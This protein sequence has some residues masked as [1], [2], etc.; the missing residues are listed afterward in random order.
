MSRYD[1]RTTLFN[2]KGRL[3]QVEY[4]L[5]AI[6]HASTALGI[7]AEDGVLLAT[8]KKIPSK[9]LEVRRSEKI[10]QIDKHIGCAVAG[11]T[12]DSNHIID[13]IRVSAQRHRVRFSEPTSVEAL[14]TT[15]ADHMQAYTQFGG[16][17]PFGVSFLLAGYDPLLGFQLFQVEPSGVLLAWKAT[18]I[19]QNSGLAISTLRSALRE[20][21]GEASAWGVRKV[22]LDE[23][24]R[25]AVKVF[26]KSIDRSSLSADK[27]EFASLRLVDGAPSFEFVPPDV[28]ARLLR[29]QEQEVQEE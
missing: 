29:E 25:L 17:R 24:M 15:I 9:L 20:K 7:L 3:F 22:D 12:S 18:A 10:Y 16:L 2:P 6:N 19:G 21:E 27:L 26:S 4:A 13:R 8:E 28:I 11:I 23:A 1:T 14:A 5:E